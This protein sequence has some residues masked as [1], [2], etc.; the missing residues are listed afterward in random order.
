MA[1]DLLLFI[2][3]V[4]IVTNVTDSIGYHQWWIQDFPLG[5]CQA[6]GGTPTSDIGA[7]WQ[8]HMQKQKNWI[9]LGGH[10]PEAPPGSANDHSLHGSIMGCSLRVTRAGVAGRE[11]EC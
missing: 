3:L 2:L 4:S 6:I 7:F 5:G 10:M 11:C 8:K 1:G 9:L